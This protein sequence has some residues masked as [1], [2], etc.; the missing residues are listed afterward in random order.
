MNV[1]SVNLTTD[2]DTYGR[3]EIAVN[4][5]AAGPRLGKD[6]QRAIKAV[7]AGNWSVR[8]ESDGSEVVTADGIDLH[9]G[10]YT[11][12]LV[13]VH[14]DSTAE[15][16]GGRGLVVLDT[17]VTP[18]LEAEGWAKDR[19]RELQDARRNG[20]FDVSDRISV[21]LVVPS[22]YLDRARTHADMIAGEVLA[23]TFDVVEAD[24]VDA[25]EQGSVAGAIELGDGVSA[26]VAKA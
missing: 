24:G 19:V 8:T 13:A 14:P 6:V 12:K 3:Y 2:A 17:A 20:G 9:D 1:K 10:E 26:D 4:A 23:T 25:D 11:R 18:E 22:E 5:R 16:P 15:L 21:R 7:K